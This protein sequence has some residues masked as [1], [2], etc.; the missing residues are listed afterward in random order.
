MIGYGAEDDNFV[1]E[2]TYNYGIR[3][4]KHGNDY[5]YLEINSNTVFEN[6]KNSGYSH[7]LDQTGSVKL[8]DPNGYKF[9]VKP[10]FDK[11]KV[12]GLSLFCT[13]I[14]QSRSYWTQ[15]IGLEI[16]SESDRS[17]VL[18]VAQDQ[19]KLELKLADG[20]AVN[21]E[22]AYGRIAFACPTD[23]LD[24]TEQKAKESNH[25]VLTSLVSLDTPGKATVHVIILA[26][27]DGHEICMVGDEG[28]RHL[29]KTDK[30]ADDLLDTAMANDNSDEWL[31]NN[32]FINKK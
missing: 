6:V 32:R 15:I 28:F 1:A 21:H 30:N 5:N 3:E 29:S 23:Q 12:T 17:V 11:P 27:P 20:Q 19:L 22:T 9:L 2:L 31:K 4:Y 25:T 7:E 10:E 13:N 18:G 14:E 24:K 16:V 8:V 26:D